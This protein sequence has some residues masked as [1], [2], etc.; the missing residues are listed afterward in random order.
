ML[1]VFS[2]SFASDKFPFRCFFAYIHVMHKNNNNNNNNNLRFYFVH[3]GGL[4]S[5]IS[6]CLLLIIA[7]FGESFYAAPRSQQKE[8]NYIGE[9]TKHVMAWQREGNIVK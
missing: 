9:T 1:R 3:D 4:Y 7:S 2:V 5:S 6:V 8:R